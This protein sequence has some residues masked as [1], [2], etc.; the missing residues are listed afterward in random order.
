MTWHVKRAFARI[1]KDADPD[2]RFVRA[3]ELKIREEISP[4]RPVR[5]RWKVALISLSGIFAVSAGTGSYAYA[6]DAVV[7]GHA[8]YPVREQMEKIRVRFARDAEHKTQAEIHL[9]M[10]RLHEQ[11]LLE[12]RRAAIPVRH[13]DRYQETRRRIVDRLEQMP[14]ETRNQFIRQIN[15]M[16]HGLPDGAAAYFYNRLPKLEPV[17]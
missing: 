15:E 17:R 5:F 7:P 12:R 11:Q 9:M 14:P 4:K 1:G 6:A 13:L 16:E 2:P 10:R 8:L 3:L